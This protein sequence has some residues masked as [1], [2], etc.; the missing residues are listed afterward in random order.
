[1]TRPPCT[2]CSA[3]SRSGTGRAP[4][5]S[6]SRGNRSIHRVGAPAVRGWRGSTRTSAH[7]PAAASATKGRVP[8]MSKTI[9]VVSQR[10]TLHTPRAHTVYEVADTPRIR[11]LLDAGILTDPDALP[12]APPPPPPVEPSRADLIAEAQG[13]DIQVGSSWSK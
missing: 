3:T 8:T 10:V 4:I 12:D 1:T 5:R 9:R 7:Q 2:R 11:A 13:L 6:S